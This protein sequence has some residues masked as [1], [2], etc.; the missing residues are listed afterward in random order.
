MT[1]VAVAGGATTIL[2]RCHCK[3]NCL[4]PLAD[5]D[6]TVVTPAGVV[7]ADHVNPVYP[8]DTLPLD[9]TETGR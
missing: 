6:A 8:G 2:A 3:P 1:A 9:F 5:D 7:L 4:W